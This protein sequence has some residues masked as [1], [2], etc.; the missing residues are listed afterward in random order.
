MVEARLYKSRSDLD[1]F[2]YLLVELRAINTIRREIHV[3]PDEENPTLSFHLRI[4][5]GIRAELQTRDVWEESYREDVE[6]LE[7]EI[8]DL[9]QPESQPN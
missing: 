3:K 5:S 4:Y 1:L 8:A 9:L 2:D 6:K 7:G